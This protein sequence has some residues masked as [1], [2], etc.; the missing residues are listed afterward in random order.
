MNILMKFTTLALNA[1]SGPGGDIS[2]EASPD[3]GSQD[4]PPERTNTS[5][6]DVVKSIKNSTV[7]LNW[8]QRT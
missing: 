6:R 4:Q 7:E 1:G 8:N 2:R 3:R 5:V